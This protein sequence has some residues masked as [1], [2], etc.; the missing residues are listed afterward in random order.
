MWVG[1]K[2][3]HEGVHWRGQHSPTEVTLTV[4]SQTGYEDLAAS[5]RQR[6]FIRMTSQQANKTLPPAAAVLPEVPSKCYGLPRKPSRIPTT[7]GCRW[8]PP[9]ACEQQDG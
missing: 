6:C 1:M 5:K 2:P 4:D 8:D 3:G 7:W 9:V